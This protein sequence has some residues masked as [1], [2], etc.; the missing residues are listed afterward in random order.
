MRW[1]GVALIGIVRHWYACLLWLVMMLCY[2]HRTR[3][4]SLDIQINNGKQDIYESGPSKKKYPPGDLS[5]GD[6]VLVSETP[7]IRQYIIKNT[8]QPKIPE[9]D[10]E[11]NNTYSLNNP[12]FSPYIVRVSWVPSCRNH[13]HPAKSYSQQSILSFTRN[14]SAFIY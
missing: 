4:W 7:R 12:G 2:L 3:I 13:L 1:T 8:P 9:T 11:K 10:E 14:F 6:V 5:L